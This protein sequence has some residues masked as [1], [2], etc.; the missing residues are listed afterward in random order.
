MYYSL[1][2]NKIRSILIVH[3]F[4]NFYTTLEAHV[5]YAALL[6]RD[7][8]PYMK[9]FLYLIIDCPC[10]YTNTVV[11]KYQPEFCYENILQR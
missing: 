9:Q 4:L 11:L 8:F 7:I 2:K 6:L 5:Q 1:F 3:H 10:F